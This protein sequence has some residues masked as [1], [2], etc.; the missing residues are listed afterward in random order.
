MSSH[1]FLSLKTSLIPQET[2]DNLPEYGLCLFSNDSL[3]NGGEPSRV[4]IDGYNEL[5]DAVI[6]SNTINN[7]LQWSDDPSSI[8]ALILNPSNVIP[9]TSDEFKIVKGDINS[10]WYEEAII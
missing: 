8:V 5:G 2:K 1:N 10:I 9:Y 6:I 4:L 7:W 3:L